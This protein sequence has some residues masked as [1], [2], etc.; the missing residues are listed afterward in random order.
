MWEHVTDANL[1]LLPPQRVR[2]TKR[3][4]APRTLF[5]LRK[6]GGIWFL[7]IGRIN[8]SWCVSR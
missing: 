6:V 2:S 5:G 1:M 3:T 4:R 7:R 8:V